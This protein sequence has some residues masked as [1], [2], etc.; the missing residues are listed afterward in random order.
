MAGPR[1]KRDECHRAPLRRHRDRRERQRDQDH[2]G[3]T[4]TATCEVI[5]K[6][7]DKP[8]LRLRTTVTNQDGLV[9]TEGEAVVKKPR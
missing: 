7:D 9:V 5:H 1:R 8:I 3:D 2:H 4:L 6:R